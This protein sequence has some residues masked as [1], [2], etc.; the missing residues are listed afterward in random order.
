[1]IS[2]QLAE[3][4]ILI[5]KRETGHDIS[6]KY[7]IQRKTFLEGKIVSHFNYLACD[8]ILMLKYLLLFRLNMKMFV[9]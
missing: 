4:A 1:M 7:A 9:I 5:S 3:T 2:K 6:G 8:I